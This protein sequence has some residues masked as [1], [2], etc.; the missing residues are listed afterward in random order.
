M[1]AIKRLFFWGCNMEAINF[2]NQS[3]TSQKPQI[4]KRHYYVC[5]AI[6]I[7]ALVGMILFFTKLL[8]AHRLVIQ[9]KLALE[10]LVEQYQVRQQRANTLKEL[11]VKAQEM[12]ILLKGQ[13]YPLAQF[14]GYLDKIIPTDVR[15]I[16]V[17]SSKNITLTGY[18]RKGS[19]LYTFVQKLIEKNGRVELLK[20]STEMIEDEELILFSLLIHP[21]E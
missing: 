2:F 15:L 14:L 5:F 18:S 20:T 6:F 9:E 10:L 12:L 17:S 3:L 7:I 1:Y 8:R 11:K 4:S 16:Q 19:S 13:R 21:Q